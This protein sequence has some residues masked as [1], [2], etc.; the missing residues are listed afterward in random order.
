M[1]KPFIPSTLIERF[2]AE[3]S[4]IPRPSEHEQAVSD[5]VCS[6][7]KRLGRKYVQDAMGNVIVW[8]DA[9]PGRGDEP[10][11]MLQAHLDMVTVCA[12]NTT[13]NFFKDPLRLFVDEEG[14]VRA[15]NTTLGADDGYGVAY[16]FGCL[17]ET[18]SHPPLECV[19]T[20]QEE[21]GCYGAQALDT[22]LL[23]ALRMIGLD[24]MGE[25]IENT[26]CVS[27]Y[28]SNKL[29]VTKNLDTKDASGVLLHIQLDGVQ[30]IR[31]KLTVHPERGNAI[32]MLTRLL[33]KLP[34]Q[35]RLVS[36]A[37]GE[38]ENYNP[39]TCKADVILPMDTDQEAIS[40]LLNRELGQIDFEVND[41]AQ[42]LR[43]SMEFKQDTAFALTADDTRN[44]LGLIDL[45]PSE[46]VEIRGQDDRMIATN[47]V[48]IVSFHQGTFSL[49]MSD[50]GQNPGCIEGI[51]RRVQHICKLSGYSLARE[52]RYVPWEYRPDSPLLK[53]TAQLMREKY[54]Q[55]MVE[56]ICPGGLELCDFLPKMNGLDCVMFA[57]IGGECHST[58]EWMNLASFNRV[59]DFLKELLGRI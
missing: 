58:K 30:P 21:N 55:G 51:E 46:T 1:M 15:D 10:A 53:A 27:C 18:F 2:F 45:M 24:V 59:Y 9:S 29:T 20:V 44:L 13:H 40:S 32:K 12:P 3:I 38:A 28:C 11:V 22:S 50:R 57:P 33:L 39:V 31:S 6:V 5:Y 48:G 16:L 4:S 43:L 41:G 19:F 23:S 49:I 34:G 47:N 7:A 26:C 52:T 35:V 37:G 25:P 14:C 17:T 42:A 56:N 54:G 8:K 36:M